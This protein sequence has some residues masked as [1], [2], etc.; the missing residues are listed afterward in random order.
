MSEKNV[1]I[2]R[3]LHEGWLRGEIGL[4]KLDPEISMVESQT[5]R[6]WGWPTRRR[7]ACADALAGQSRWRGSRLRTQ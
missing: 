4:D 3:S 2:V 5:L 1:K 7:A 6:T